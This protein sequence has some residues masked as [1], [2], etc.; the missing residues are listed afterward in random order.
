MK[1]FP[2]N[3]RDWVMHFVTSGSVGIIVNDTLGPFFRTHK[4]L[5][6]GDPFSPL[7]FNLVADSL[8][9]LIK[10][11]HEH[12]LF[13]GVVPELVSGGLS[14][15]QYADDTI[16]L[17]DGDMQGA[18][19]LKFILC[20]FEHLTGLKINFHKSEVY[21]FGQAVE[22]QLDYAE[23]FTCRIGSLPFKYLG[24]PMHCRKLSN[25]DWKPT[26]EKVENKLSSWKGR[27]LSLGGR[28]VLLNSCLSNVPSYM[29]SL[30]PIP[31]GVLKRIDFFRTRLL[32]QEEENVKKYHLVNWP[33]ICQ[34]RD[35]GG[36]GVTDI[37]I[38]NICLLCKWLWKLETSMVFGNN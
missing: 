1:G 36:L 28:L 16:F 27:F 2:D 4:G 5:R 21:C 18:R 11:A 15:L 13:K 31:R 37:S 26:E 12:G 20:L 6:Q 32:W 29:L 30:F 3:Y 9:I 14:M 35:Q 38:K 24:M 19:N 23:I 22:R 17:F 34:P 33:V 8:T 25:S 10:R 7:L